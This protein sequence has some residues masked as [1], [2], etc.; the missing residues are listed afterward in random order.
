MRR[1]WGVAALCGVVVLFVLLWLVL[2]VLLLGQWV[3][4]WCSRRSRGR[5]D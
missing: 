3:L 2:F 4:L 1:E 5:R